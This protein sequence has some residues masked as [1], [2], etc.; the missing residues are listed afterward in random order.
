MARPI[1][2]RKIGSTG[3]KTYEEVYYYVY[4][5]MRSLKI[6]F[7]SVKQ[8]LRTKIYFEATSTNIRSSIPPRTFFSSTDL[9]PYHIYSKKMKIN[10]LELLSS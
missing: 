3:K 5:C 1:L 7:L 9:D 10:L 6:M 4:L 2:L 8:Y